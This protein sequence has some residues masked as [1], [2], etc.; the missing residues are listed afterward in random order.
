[1]TPEERL[2]DNQRRKDYRARQ[3]AEKKKAGTYTARS[4]LPNVFRRVPENE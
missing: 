3:I 1:M 4:K 2:A